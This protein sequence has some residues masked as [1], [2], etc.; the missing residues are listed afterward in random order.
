MSKFKLGS[1]V[2][3]VDAGMS[4]NEDG[5]IGEIVEISKSSGMARVNV[6]GRFHSG[7]WQLFKELELIPE[8]LKVGDI[9]RVI[10]TTGGTCNKL[11]SIG[12]IT[13][14]HEVHEARVQCLPGRSYGNW[15]LYKF[16]KKITPEECSE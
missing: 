13:E 4:A 12:V 14:T 8:P 16:L 15:S 10:D 3:V 1:K 7:N 11:N 2:V 5:D 9:V 6:P